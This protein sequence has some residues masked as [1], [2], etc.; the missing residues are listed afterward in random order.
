MSSKNLSGW[1]LIAGPILTFVVIGIL[2][3][4]LI[5]DGETSAESVKEMVENLQLSKIL[6]AVGSLAFVSTFIGLAMLAWSMHGEEQPGSAYA[7]VAGIIFVG[8]TAIGM[9]ATGMNYGIM[10]AAAKNLTEAIQIDAVSNN[11]LFPGLFWFWG[12]GNVVLGTAIVI[13]KNLHEI[14]GWV[15]VVIG[16]LMS[17]LTIV[18]VDVNDGVGFGIWIVLSLITVAAGVLTLRGNQSS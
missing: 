16:I 18:D 13:Q 3:S 10:D 17:L 6:V 11:G 2:W 1:L 5:G 7:S 8:I 9:A 4:I 15:F 12:I 14:L